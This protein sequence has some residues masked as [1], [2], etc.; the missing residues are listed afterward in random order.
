MITK[1]ISEGQT[2]IEP[3]KG[4][5]CV[6]MIKGFEFVMITTVEKFNSNLDS[7]LATNYEESNDIKYLTDKAVELWDKE[8]V[9]IL[10]N[11]PAEEEQIFKT[12][13]IYG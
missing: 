10:T 8:D 11:L 12:H 13:V 2:G 7:H 4:K 3:E 1:I 9:R 5:Y 6:F